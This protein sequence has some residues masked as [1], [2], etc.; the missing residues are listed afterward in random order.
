MIKKK[1]NRQRRGHC[2]KTKR[3]QHL[4]RVIAK[5]P[6]EVALLFLV[7]DSLECNKTSTESV[8]RPQ[9][10]LFINNSSKTSIQRLGT[11]GR[12]G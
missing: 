9:E 11:I 4:T 8:F 6:F 2:D 12:A 10:E 5:V 7:E 1:M 3:M